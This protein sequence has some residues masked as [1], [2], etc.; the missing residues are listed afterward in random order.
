[1]NLKALN[2]SMFLAAEHLFE[3][4]KHLMPISPEYGERLMLEADE[5]LSMIKPEVEK[6]SDEKLDGILDE[7]L[8]V[9]IE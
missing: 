1:M 9:E 3:A 6:V 4:G 2:R 8:N 7:I 5:I